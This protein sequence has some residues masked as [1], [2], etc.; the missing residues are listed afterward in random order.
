[1]PKVKVRGVPEAVR[2]FGKVSKR[3]KNTYPVMQIAAKEMRT[4]IREDVFGRE[5]NPAGT[6]W[7]PLAPSTRNQRTAR[8]SGRTGT[9]RSQNHLSGAKGPKGSGNSRLGVKR[10]FFARNA[11]APILDLTGKLKRSVRVAARKNSI[12]IGIQGD[13]ETVLKAK[14]HMYG[15]SKSGA[16]RTSD[17]PR[18]A[19]LPLN[20]QGR[21][22]FAA[23]P[24]KIW[25]DRTI[26]AMN[27]Y[28]ATGKLPGLGYARGVR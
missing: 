16:L 18:R 20:K 14:I 5:S 1:M 23:G 15:A 2:D 26:V 28:V 13:A 11:S 27:K 17:I 6:K 7:L 4:I 8:N 10:S 3:V 9:P 19:F 22:S 12:R 24:V 21:A 25:S